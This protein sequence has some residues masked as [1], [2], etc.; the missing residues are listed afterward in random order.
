LFPSPDCAT[1][2]LLS[3]F[4]LPRPSLTCKLSICCNVCAT[5]SARL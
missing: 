4:S 5:Q 3:R 2:I 1:I